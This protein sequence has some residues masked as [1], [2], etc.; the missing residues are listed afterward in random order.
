MES[1]VTRFQHQACHFARVGPRCDRN[2]L[3]P[4][5]Q[6]PLRIGHRDAEQRG[7]TD[8]S[9]GADLHEVSLDR[10]RRFRFWRIGMDNLNGSALSVRGSRA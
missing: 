8:S 3:E 5:A 6:L 7:Q 9:C 1:P 4:A 10:L 2:I